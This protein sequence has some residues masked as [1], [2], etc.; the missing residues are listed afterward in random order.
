VVSRS[1]SPVLGLGQ[2]AVACAAARLRHGWHERGFAGFS[3]RRRRVSAQARSGVDRGSGRAEQW[4]ACV[5]GRDGI[6]TEG[7]ERHRSISEG[8]RGMRALGGL[9]RVVWAE[10]VRRRGEPR[11]RGHRAGVGEGAGGA[12]RPR[13]VVLITAL[14]QRARTYGSGETRERAARRRPPPIA[15]AEGGIRRRVS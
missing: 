4:G 10:F 14:E 1:V 2:D 13:T 7:E 5:A 11:G 12:S 9:G 3:A 15:A 6:S 8:G